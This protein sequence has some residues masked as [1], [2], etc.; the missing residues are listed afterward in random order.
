MK[1]S[2]TVILPVLRMVPI[3]QTYLF[4]TNL[5]L[6]GELPEH[7][8]FCSFKS[9]CVRRRRVEL[10]MAERDASHSGAN[11]RGRCSLGQSWSST[12]HPVIHSLVYSTNICWVF[13]RHSRKP[14]TLH[15][16]HTHSLIREVTPLTPF[17]RW[18]NWGSMRLKPGPKVTQLMNNPG[19]QRSS[20]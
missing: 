3:L 19:A 12:K 18:E 9:P 2:V 8:G 20:K 7:S 6:H 1:L 13:V 4:N 15:A 5:E 10:G 14:F 11:L 16:I 17:Y